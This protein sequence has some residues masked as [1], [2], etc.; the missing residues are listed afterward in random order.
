[1]N[2]AGALIVKL[3]Q[4]IYVASSS[5][6]GSA[7]SG[8]YAPPEF[9]NSTHPTRGATLKNA[10]VT[11]GKPPSSP[12]EC[13]REAGPCLFNVEGDP[14]EYVNQAKNQ[15]EIVKTMLQWLDQYQNTMVPPRNKPFDPRAN[16][17]N[18]GGV[19]SPWMDE[20]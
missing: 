11:C 5:P 1:M 8:W 13:T 9:E 19:W 16:P 15:P 4:L 14:C 18:F 12:P 17:N 20:E 7:W 6:I 2:S 10:V 3:T